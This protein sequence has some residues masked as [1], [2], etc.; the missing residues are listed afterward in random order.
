MRRPAAVEAEV[1]GSVNQAGAEVVMPEPVGDHPAGQRVLRVR[2]NLKLYVNTPCLYIP[3]LSSSPS[4][5][6]SP[7]VRVSH[8]C[9]HQV[10]V[11][12]L[13]GIVRPERMSVSSLI[14]I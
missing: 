2:P 11:R 3:T 5:Y 12:R 9:M 10:V 6:P 1:V 14:D 8:S 13:G 7:V 4:A